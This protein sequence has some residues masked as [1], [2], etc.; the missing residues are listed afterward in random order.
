MNNSKTAL[1]LIS[2]MIAGYVTI[3]YTLHIVSL[4]DQ[5]RLVSVSI[6]LRVEKQR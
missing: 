5:D 4:A 3:R 1:T 6:V 2:L